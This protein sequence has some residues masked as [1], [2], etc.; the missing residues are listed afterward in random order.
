MKGRITWLILAMVEVIS[1]ALKIW[2]GIGAFNSV[3]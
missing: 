1:W 3:H 2:A